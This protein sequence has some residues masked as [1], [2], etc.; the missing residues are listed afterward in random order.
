MENQQPASSWNSKKQTIIWTVIALAIALAT[1]SYFQY[2]KKHPSTDDAYVQAAVVQMAPQ[3]SGPIAQIHVANNEAVTKG[4]SLITIEPIIFMNAVLK[5]KAGLQLAAQ[6]MQM[7]SKAIDIVKAQVVQ[8]QAQLL[9]EQQ[10]YKRIQSLLQNDQIAV[11]KGDDAKAK[12]DV[13]KA[14]LNAIKSTLA[15]A[16]KNLGT[17]GHLNAQIQQAKATLALA[18][19][20]LDYTDIKAPASGHI[21]NFHLRE[22]TTV[23]AGQKLFQLIENNHWWVD[24]HFKETQLGNIQ[25]GQLATIKIDMYPGQTFQG[26]VDSVS[27]GSGAAFSLLPP[28]NATGNWVKVTQR[29]TVKITLDDPDPKYPLRVGASSKVTI[30]TQPAD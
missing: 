20:N 16:E 28:E 18:K 27:R 14:R 29:F 17:A 7:D 26:H 22:G 5:A 23:Q 13:A 19:K 3:I 12:L 9:A 11:A 6:H 8:A 10:R 21:T 4:Q 24:A 30:D 1:Y 15:K 2:R 25:P